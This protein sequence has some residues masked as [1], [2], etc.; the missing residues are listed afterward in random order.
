MSFRILALSDNQH[1][2][3]AP[4]ECIDDFELIETNDIRPETVQE[5]FPD[6]LLTPGCDWYHTASCI[7]EARRLQ[8][9]SLLL[10]DGVIEWR[11]QWENPKFG[12]GDGAPYNQPVT[13]DKV[14]CIGWQSARTL[15]AWGNVGKC[16]IVGVPRF[17]H[18][19]ESPVPPPPDIHPKRLLVMTANTPGFTPEQ[20]ARVEQAL[21]DLKELLINQDEWEP[22]W[23]VR[24]GLDKQ[25]GL[26]D[27][28]PYLVQKPLRDVLT[29]AHA[30]ITTP[31]TALLE[32]M[33]AK[34]PSAILDYTNSP[35]YIPAAWVVTSR[36]HMTRVLG[37]LGNPS[38]AKLLFQDEVLHNS[39]ECYSPALTRLVKLI[40]QMSEIGRI[41]RQN[42]Q[43]IALPW[44]IVWDDYSGYAMQSQYFDPQKLYPNHKILGMTDIEKIRL[45]LI[46]ANKEL[47]MLR[48]KARSRSLGYWLG[49]L[50]MKI[51]QMAK[52]ARFGR[53][54]VNA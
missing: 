1:H 37:E 14:A 32:A 22:I 9:P 25:L 3:F 51:T 49:L 21:I 23:R 7:D 46:H 26:S 53:S 11:H 43:C 4:L 35:L 15:E 45:D 50:L 19:I 38:Q 28:F 18:Y 30:V 52:K 31:S 27:R 41:A 39:L 33:L 42:Q 36:E 54:W 8:I 24:R 40:T 16:E 12:A 29:Q 44:R 10:M 34:R 5:V 47:S 6:L 2:H 17:D 20:V 13:T 48:G